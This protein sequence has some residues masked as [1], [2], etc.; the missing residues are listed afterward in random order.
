MITQSKKYLQTILSIVLLLL[1]LDHALKEIKYYTTFQ[2][3][4]ENLEEK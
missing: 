3:S 1:S 4:N 2:L